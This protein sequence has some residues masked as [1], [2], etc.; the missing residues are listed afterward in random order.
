ML[1]LVGIPVLSALV[2]AWRGQVRLS[3]W[4]RSLHPGQLL[5]LWG[6]ASAFL[7]GVVTLYA[8]IEPDLDVIEN[9]LV[10]TALVGLF[11]WMVVFLSCSTWP[12]LAAR[13]GAANVVAGALLGPLI[14]AWSVGMLV[15][16]AYLAGSELVD[17]EPVPIYDTGPDQVEWP[18][19]L[20]AEKEFVVLSPGD[21][22]ARPSNSAMALTPRSAGTCMWSAR[23]TVPSTPGRSRAAC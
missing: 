20:P 21:A 2:A 9:F 22:N 14:C 1:A 23:P 17:P 10:L 8:A 3:R 19:P 11:L 16:V 4:L 13:E 6:L 7:W 15:L 18:R 5:F 12:A